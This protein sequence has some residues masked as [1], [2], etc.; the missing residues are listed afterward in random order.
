MIIGFDAKRAFLN[1]TGL[2]NYSRTIISNLC[3]IFK[4]HQY[5]AFTPRVDQNVHAQQMLQ[6]D[7][8]DIVTAPKLMPKSVWRSWGIVNTIKEKDLNVYHGLS[9]ELPFNAKRMSCKK[10]VTI[11]DL[12]FES[13]P[14]YY[15]SIDRKIYHYKFKNSAEQAD[16]VIA[17]SEFTKK[18]IVEKYNVAPQKVE[19]LY[20]DVATIFKKEYSA[21]QLDF[22][23]RKYNLPEYFLLQVGSIEKRKNAKLTIAA[24]KHT[25]YDLPLV[26]IG[27][28]TAYL[29]ELEAYIEKEKMMDRVIFLHHVG[30]FDLPLIYRQ[31]MAFIYPSRIEGFGIPI[32]EAHYATIPVIAA[33]GSCLEESGG[34]QALYVSPDNAEELGNAIDKVIDGSFSVDINALTKHLQQFDEKLLTHKLMNIYQS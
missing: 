26:I 20:Q 24:L 34:T 12:I 31:A 29:K 19:V 33:T 9:N 32:L 28:P 21:T 30:Y 13:H 5:Y 4:E 6:W 17:T 23:N 15:P 10:V 22:V 16:V 8:L 1:N 7:C 18:Q 14:Q 27:K 25:R 3:Q 11:H 2:G